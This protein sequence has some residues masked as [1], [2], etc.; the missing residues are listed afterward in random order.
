MKR[1]ATDVLRRGFNLLIANWPVI[2]IRIVESILFLIIIF[3]AV[4]AAIAPIIVAAGLG[5]LSDITN[6]SSAILQHW[7]LL[8]YA[9]IV[10]A[11][12]LVILVAIHAFV[13][14][15]VTQILVDSE[16]QG[17][18]PAFNMDRLIAG[19]RSGWW[20]IFWIYNL[21]WSIAGL[22]LLVPLIAT[23]AGMVVVSDATGRI[24][25][26]CA[27]LVFVIVLGLPIAIIAAV[28]TQKAIAVCLSRNASASDS[29]R[30]ARQEMRL[31]MSRHFVVAFIILV[32][33]IGG[34]GLISI[35]S[36]PISFM[37]QHQP[38]LVAFTAPVQIAVS[39]A[40]TI[41]SAATGAWLLASFVA[42]TE[43]R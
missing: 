41:F 35:V 10:I 19:G 18:K 13:D 32:V 4:I 39:F 14:G 7:M 43:E 16:R 3:A 17:V 23:L 9:L 38:L 2:A 20:A 5:N 1:T 31:D 21:V 26:G 25:I 34:G 6:A 8:I 40:Q 30:I 27:G 22:I 37:P 11:V 28:W 12:L 42:L 24:V 29:M 36:M 33:S 15:G